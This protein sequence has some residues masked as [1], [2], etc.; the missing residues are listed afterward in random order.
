MGAP[1]DR[2]L[3]AL[4]AVLAIK[5]RR[6]ERAEDTAYREQ[7]QANWEKAFEQSKTMS[8]KMYNLQQANAESERAARELT[9]EQ[10]QQQIG[11]AYQMGYPLP[12]GVTISNI[13]QQ[14]GTLQG[15]PQPQGLSGI[16][17]PQGLGETPLAPDITQQRATLTFPGGATQEVSTPEAYQARLLQ[18]KQA[19]AQAANTM[20]LDLFKQEH[21]ITAQDQLNLKAYDFSQQLALKKMEIDSKERIDKANN[22]TKLQVKAIGDKMG[23][24]S[25]ISI[26]PET[27][28]VTQEPINVEDKVGPSYGALKNWTLSTEDYKKQD[29]YADVVFDDLRKQGYQPATKQDIDTMTH[30]QNA[31]FALKSLYQANMIKQQHPI[32]VN[33]PWT[34]AHK[35]FEAAKGS[36]NQYLPGLIVFN[37][38][39]K[40]A[41]GVEVNL[42]KGGT[43]PLESILSQ[44][45]ENAASLYNNNVGFIDQTLARLTARLGKQQKQEVYD[46]FN[47][48]INGGVP[49]MPGAKSQSPGFAPTTPITAPESKPSPFTATKPSTAKEKA[50]S[51]SQ[52]AQWKSTPD[53]NAPFKNTTPL[54][55][56]G[57]SFTGSK[58]FVR[59][60]SDGRLGTINK[61]D[62]DSRIYDKLGEQ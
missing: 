10:A 29:K 13:P 39:V 35:D 26:D 20:A 7:Q 6:Q 17:Q 47:S 33:I 27:G 21:G 8:E 61:Y 52:A 62:W 60:K 24:Y 30:A 23:P 34:Q 42:T 15:I 19:E 55:N 22:A 37:N 51:G 57:Q 58:I 49:L 43:N 32:E 44:S 50:F 9:M 59:R 25:N 2:V 1:I 4:Q 46:Q 38:D 16:S 18:Q 53:Y 14:A 31:T 28:Q 36:F 56:L 12:R 45:P 3:G 40:R 5:E 54:P 11:G 41:T 48:T